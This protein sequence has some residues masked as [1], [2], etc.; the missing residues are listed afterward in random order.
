[1]GEGPAQ[2]CVAGAQGQAPTQKLQSFAASIAIGG[3]RVEA[4]S[5]T[6]AKKIRSAHLRGL[7]GRRHQR[8]GQKEA[9]PAREGECKAF[10]GCR[11]AAGEMLQ[12]MAGWLR[13][14]P[15]RG[16]TGC[17]YYCTAS[18]VSNPSEGLSPSPQA[19]PPKSPGRAPAVGS[20]R[21]LPPQ[22]RPLHVPRDQ[23]GVAW[24]EGQHRERQEDGR[25]PVVVR[26]RRQGRRQAQVQQAFVGFGVGRGR[27]RTFVCLSCLYWKG[28]NRRGGGCRSRMTATF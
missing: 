15:K 28:V 7:K 4:T 27:A 18:K 20:R 13:T 22:H 10:G 8:L 25:E 23:R 16:A 9:C 6:F 2:D 12:E 11:Q 14:G 5:C 24:R 3:T 26:R 19:P 17:S 1:V 21:R